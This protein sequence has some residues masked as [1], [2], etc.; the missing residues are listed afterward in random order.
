MHA[1]T[2]QVQL[3]PPPEIPPIPKGRRPPAAIIGIMSVPDV[4][5][6]S[7]AYQAADK[8]FGARRKK[9][10][11]D[12]Q[13]EQATLRD[14]GQTLANDRA[15]A[16]AGADPPN[17]AGAAGPHHRFA[18]QVRRAQPDHPGSRPVRDGADRADDGAVVAAGRAGA[19]DQPGAEPAQM[20]GTTADFDLTPAGRREVLNKVLPSVVI[21]PDGVSPSWHIEAAG[22]RTP[23]RPRR[24][25]QR[26]PREAARGARSPESAWRRL[27]AARP[28]EA[29]TACRANS[30][31]SNVSGLA[32]R[33]SAIRASSS[34]AARHAWPRWRDAADAEAPPRRLMLHGV[35]PLQTAGADDVS[36]LDNRKY[37]PA[38]ERHAAPAR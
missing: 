9:L 20:L 6:A 15:E 23:A 22:G 16:D 33:S 38:L 17:G 2:A 18:A 14:L 10:N 12:A 19:R 28:D 5:R 32:R 35:A 13:K 24:L 3:P 29:L 31:R 37:L 1:A 11:E 7:T 25:P 27:A 30:M 26:R 4:L 34:A 8:V 21:P 36:F